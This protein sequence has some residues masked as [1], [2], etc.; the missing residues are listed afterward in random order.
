MVTVNPLPKIPFHLGRFYT[1]TILVNFLLWLPMWIIYLQQVRGMSL[2]LIGIM[3]GVGFVISAIAEVP[4]GAVADRYGRKVSLLI[5]SVAF[6]LLTVAYGFTSWIPLLFLV[7]ILWSV[8][9]TFFTG[10]DVAFLYDGLKSA[11]R[12][13]EHSKI[14]GRYSAVV[15]GAQAV[16]ALLGGYIANSSMQQPFVWSGLACIVGGLLLFKFHEPPAEQSAKQAGGITGELK[17][18]MQLGVSYKTLRNFILFSTVLSLPTFMLLFFFVQPYILSGNINVGWVG[19]VILLLRSASVTGAALSHRITRRMK[20]SVILFSLPLMMTCCLM[21]AGWLPVLG[22]IIILSVM[23]FFSAA[24]R[25][26]LTIM[27]NR[28]IP[29]H[30]RATVLSMQSLLFTLMLAGTQTI[31]SSVVD[32]FGFP[33]LFFILA[34]LIGLV[35]GLFL[36]F[37]LRSYQHAVISEDPTSQSKEAL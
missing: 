9:Q 8:S 32:H 1:H 36:V 35:G 6:G 4:A 16:A 30:S 29:S 19:A 21:I 3:Q 13:A 14:M 10:A 12:E 31:L 27:L 5:G 37:N 17:A 26:V 2:A 22:G 15:Q 23:G 24:M 7:H 33:A 20:E 18:A 34:V 25:P 28:M 11:G